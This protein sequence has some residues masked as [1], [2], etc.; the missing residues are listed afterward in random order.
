VQFNASFG[1]KVF[2]K[3]QKDI[4]DQDPKLV[5]YRL[6]LITEEVG[7]LK[8][9]IQNKDMKEVID[10]LADILVVVYGCGASFG[11]DLDRAYDIVH[12]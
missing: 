8:E 2:D 5:K 10:G 11:I 4:F 6:D 3:V 1:I 12:R 9:A 7:E